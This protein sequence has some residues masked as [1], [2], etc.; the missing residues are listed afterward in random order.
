M[1][2]GKSIN[3]CNE[4]DKKSINLYNEEDKKI[5]QSLQ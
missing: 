3:L 1:E 2:I 4:E 5:N